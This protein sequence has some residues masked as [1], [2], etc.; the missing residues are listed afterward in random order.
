MPWKALKPGSRVNSVTTTLPLQ[1][2]CYLLTRAR[3]QMADLEQLLQ[4]YGATTLTFPTLEIQ[5]LKL[6]PQMLAHLGLRNTWWIF[7]SANGVA[8]VMDQLDTATLSEVIS[9]VSIA[10][11]GPKTAKKLSVY[12]ITPALISEVHHAEALGETLVSYFKAHKLL[13]HTQTLV[14]WQAEQG[15]ATLPQTLAQAGYEIT[16]H[17]VY[18]TLK[19]EACHG[20]AL[21]ELLQQQVPQGIIFTSPSSVRHFCECLTP[22]LQKRLGTPDYYSIGPVTSAAIRQDLGPV[23]LEAEPYTLDGLVTKL[24]AFAQQHQV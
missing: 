22:A 11:V 19:P 10:C 12:G 6:S 16:V 4:A 5:P 15:L 17:A 1:N 8:A 18:Q 21:S 2:T 14:L 24:C 7:N 3:H 23:T 20:A 13:P 9:T